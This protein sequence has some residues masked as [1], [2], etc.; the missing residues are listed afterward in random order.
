MNNFTSYHN[1]IKNRLFC[2]IHIDNELQD[3]EHNFKKVDLRCKNGGRERFRILDAQVSSAQNT[4]IG[5][6][7]W[8]GSCQG[9]ERQGLTP[10]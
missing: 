4:V 3:S 5:P 2:L 1:C 7:T 8:M 9:V 6:R 10:I